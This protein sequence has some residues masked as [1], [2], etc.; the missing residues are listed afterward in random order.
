MKHPLLSTFVIMWSACKII[1]PDL[2][3]STEKIHSL[4]LYFYLTVEKY[5]RKLPKP[6]TVNLDESKK[7]YFKQC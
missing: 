2:I 7:L 5:Y 4:Y 6:Q 3:S 1:I